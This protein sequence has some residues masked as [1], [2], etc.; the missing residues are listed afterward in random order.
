L[1]TSALWFVLLFSLKKSLLTPSHEQQARVTKRKKESKR[2][3]AIIDALDW[4]GRQQIQYELYVVAHFLK[5]FPRWS[6]ASQV[7]DSQ[8]CHC[9]F[10]LGLRVVL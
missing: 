6:E 2:L 9:T 5:E 4:N 7:R 10:R 1:L 3:K 8:L